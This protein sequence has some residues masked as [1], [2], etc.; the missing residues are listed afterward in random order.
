MAAHPNRWLIPATYGCASAEPNFVGAVP[1]EK[2][3]TF[4]VGSGEGARLGLS[5]GVGVPVDPVAP[6]VPVGVGVP[7]G[8]TSTVHVAVTTSLKNAL[9]WRALTYIR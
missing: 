8:L 3:F 4:V 7:V 6:V 1:T 9:P 2:I 5:L